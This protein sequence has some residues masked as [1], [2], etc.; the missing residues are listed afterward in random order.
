MLLDFL[1]WTELDDDRARR[2]VAAEL[3]EGDTS[4]LE[5]VTLEG[6]LAP[7]P[8]YRGVELLEVVLSIPDRTEPISLYIME[9]EARYF[10][11]DG[12]SQ[13]IHACNI[14]EELLVDGETAP[15]YLRFFCFFVRG[16]EG[17]F[18]LFERAAV[19]P[20]DGA[21]PEYV[22]QIVSQA[23][24]I[25]ASGSD[26]E[27]SWRYE[28]PVEYGGGLFVSEFRVGAD[29]N[30]RMLDDEPLL[31]KVP[32]MVLIDMPPLRPADAVASLVWTTVARLNP[33]ENTLLILVELLLERAVGSEAG[34]RLLSHFNAQGAGAPSL[35]SFAH[36][37]GSAAALVAVESPLP[38]VED[39]IRRLVEP[40]LAG[41]NI[42]WFRATT[43]AGDDTK[44][45][46]DVPSRGPAIGL[47]PFHAYRSIENPEWIAHA[48]SSRKVS[49]LIG[50]ERVEDLPA[51]LREVIDLTL[52]LPKLDADLFAALFRRLM[53]IDPPKDWN[54]E[55]THWV[56]HVH[57]SDFQ[58]PIGLGLSPA[59]TIDYIRERATGRLRDVEPVKGLGLSDLHGLGEARVFAEDLITDI[60][61]AI[62]G[63]LDW[64]HVDRG[65]LLVGDP[66]TGKTTLARAIA[67]ECG[68]R[69]INASAA[70][71]QAVG[72]LG[73]HIRAIQADF[74]RARRF[75]PSILFIDELDS[76]GNRQVFAG[77]NTQ[78]LTEVVNAVLEQIQGMDPEAPVIVIGATNYEKN[79]DPALKRAGR[80]DR[81]VRIPRPNVKGLTKIYEHYL[82]EYVGDDLADDVDP[83]TLGGLS[84]GRTGADVELYVRGALRRAR[85]ESREVCQADL[86]AEITRKPRDPSTARRLT[87]EEIDRV[88]VHEA[89]HALASCLGSSRGEEISF[90]SI[91]P[92]SDGTLGFVASLPSEKAFFTRQEYLEQL[93]VFLAG[94]AA[95]ELVFGSEQVTS[96]AG[97]SHRSSD[98]A[99]ATRAATRIV[100]QY[101]LGPEGGLLWTDEP[102][103]EQL[104]EADRLL[105]EAYERVKEKLAER[106]ADLDAIADELKDRQEMTGE[107]V[108][109]AVSDGST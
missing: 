90:V 5:S 61:E 105:R 66:G 67:Q 50:C 87:P 64:M 51:A 106:R 27:G 38:F 11:L 26:G 13:P 94:R 96:G 46:V 53:G 24:P 81:V 43:S 19:D 9:S 102:D 65:M 16:S 20:S 17:P 49:C 48:L 36:L 30:V 40:H 39:S 89:G 42:S 15:D 23:L 6:R 1:N 12:T 29:G 95:E 97:G 2:A 88:A 77:K 47:I 18:R 62:E 21:Y 45:S 101:G 34:S 108:R 44:L 37:L 28:A 10:Y 59:E 107:E 98:L 100:A 76:I 8:F 54:D 41:S 56:S 78:Y 31:D 52:E 7:L 25:R 71:W 55:D 85:R 68:I 35:D 79:I 104:E 103:A 33:G 57:H 86:V 99:V 14:L 84:L 91:V 92:R 80:L 58:Q 109:R 22:A 32:E 93:E 83:A 3:F 4:P 82:E 60:H 63:R 74:R 75:A 73:D 72:H 70:R 69:F